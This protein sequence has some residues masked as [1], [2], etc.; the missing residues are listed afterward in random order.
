MD[1]YICATNHGQ[2]GNNSVP[3]YSSASGAS[4][5]LLYNRLYQRIYQRRVRL[6]HL[7]IALEHNNQ[8]QN[9]QQY[10]SLLCV[11]TRLCWQA[12]GSVCCGGANP[13]WLGG[14]RPEGPRK[15][16]GKLL[17]GE[18]LQA[19]AW[20]NVNTL[21]V[22]PLASIPPSG[23]IVSRERAVSCQTCW[24]KRSGKHSAHRKRLRR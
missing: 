8:S 3:E 6:S 15:A 16:G 19:Y 11:Y 13:V 4:H 21:S 5:G 18:V 20:E 7:P 12:L 2:T 1:V 10:A 23:N 9:T 22:P 14:R 24:W 17:A